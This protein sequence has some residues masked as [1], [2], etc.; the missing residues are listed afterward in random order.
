M[1]PTVAEAIAQ[2]RQKIDMRDA[3][4]LSRLPA[5][6]AI[7]IFQATAAERLP[8]SHVDARVAAMFDAAAAGGAEVSEAYHQLVLLELIAHHAGPVQADPALPPVIKDWYARTFARIVDDVVQGRH[9]AGFYDHRN[10]KFQKDLGVAHRRIIPAGVQK[11]NRYTFPLGALKRSGL[12]SIAQVGF[13]LLRMGGTGPMYDMHTDSHDPALLAEF[14]P[15]GWRRFHQNAAALMEAQPDVLGMFGIGWFN[16]PD[17]KR[18]SPR[19]AYIGDLI[20]ETGGKIIRVGPS[21]GARVS[22]LATSPTRRQMFADGTY[23]P[24]DYLTLQPRAALIRW[25]RAQR[26]A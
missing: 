19:L 6:D 12:S 9:E 18:V 16:D 11:L 25:A 14:T 5:A 2:V 13:E 4:L 10:D 23:V 17:M 3:T 20:I 7:G 21:D 22:A 8:Y 15:E 1:T 24:T 26:G